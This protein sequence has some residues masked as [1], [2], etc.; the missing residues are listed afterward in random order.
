VPLPDLILVAAARKNDPDAWNTLLQQ[1]QLPLY[2]YVVELVRDETAALD[3]VQETF[4]NAV[5]Y[6][7]SLRD[8]AKFASWLFG[9]AHQKCVQHF[10]RSRRTETLFA[11]AS[12]SA[13]EDGE[14]SLDFAD[15]AAPDP[16]DR[17]IQRENADRFFALVEQLPPPQRSVLLLHVLEDFSLE[18]I[19][20]ITDAPLGT[21]K[22]RLHHAKRAL[23]QLVEANP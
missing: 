5:R 7:G 6:L 1:Q 20:A 8:D 3:V 22:S 11:P 21:V 15:P 23:R 17:L 14:K 16:R 13:A 2:A 9:I 18:E 4:A 10:R 19:A 12:A